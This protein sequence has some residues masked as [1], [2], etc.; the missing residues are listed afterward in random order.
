MFWAYGSYVGGRLLVLCSIAILARL[1]TPADFGLVAIA[2]TATVI[3]DGITDL[4]LSQALIVADDEDVERRA[5]TAWTVNMLVAVTLTLATVLFAPAAARFFEADELRTLL[6]VLAVNF[7]LRAAGT[8][9]FALAQRQIDFRTRTVAEMADV[10]VR[11]AVG[12]GL[13]LAGAGAYSL[14]G[15]YLAGSLVLTATLWILLPWRP[16]VRIRRDDLRAMLGF[17]GGLT[18]VGLMSVAISNADYVL[19][20]RELGQTQLGLYTL[21]YR[22]PELLIL[23][24]AI[25]AGM[26]LFPAMVGVARAGLADAFLTSL[27]YTLVVA[28]PLAVGLAILAEPLVLVLFGDQ[29]R[30]SVAVMQVLALFSFAYAI[31]IPAGTAYKSIGRVDVILMLAVPRT[32]LAVAGILLFVDRGIVAVAVSQAAVAALFAVIGSICA[33][34]M[35]GTGGRRIWRAAWPV[36]AAAAALGATLWIVTYLIE[37]PYLCIAA[38]A[39]LGAPVYLGC[40]WLVSRDVL[41]KLWRLAFPDGARGSG[42]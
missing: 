12:I 29:W 20:G 5:D 26:V 10:V 25:V 17:G 32:I 16:R 41:E 14:V 23:N 15:G 8:T 7:I 38:G 18:A 22:L 6:P 9:H 27:R 11:G 4:S 42:G 3:L 35:L 33:A 39:A 40:L 2:F 30:S 21:G 36:L 28:A 24:L 19:I 31:E 13:A 34:R 1:L 37:D